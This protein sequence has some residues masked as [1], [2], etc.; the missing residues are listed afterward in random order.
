MTAAPEDLHAQ[1]ASNPVW[2]HTIDL[3]PGVS[4]PGWFDLRPVVDR[5]PWPDVKGKRCLD[6]GTYDGF[7]AFELER[8]GASE[9]V[10]ADVAHH[11][12]WD[13]PPRH[14]ALGPEHLAA[15]AGEKGRGF[16]I[17][18]DA[19][20]SKVERAWCSVYDLD[21]DVLGTFDVVTC[22]S[23]LLHLRDPFRA[24]EAI[25]G[26]CRSEF[27]SV[28][29]IDFRLTAMSPKWPVLRLSGDNGQWTIPN[30]AAH[31]RMLHIAGFD[32]VRTAKPFSEPFGA[33]HPASKA[34]ARK[35]LRSIIEHT[36]LGGPGVGVSAA[37]ARVAL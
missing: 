7:L 25:R 26:M 33:A 29:Q 22:G 5:I 31:R 32:I 37:L 9:V 2:Y 18:R 24:L 10:A 17:A 8:R 36:Y 28:E 27:L 12:D 21:P 15:V 6:V 14:R 1:I 34:P 4:T 23:L 19:L 3:A 35:R 30:V 11:E 13:W 16:E 20:G